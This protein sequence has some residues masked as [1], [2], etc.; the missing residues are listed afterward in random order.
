MMSKVP[1]KALVYG[2]FAYSSVNIVEFLLRQRRKW[3]TDLTTLGRI[4][5]D[6][7]TMM[8]KRL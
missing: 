3:R 5:S 1:V 8:L 7:L 4:H 6:K 2:Q